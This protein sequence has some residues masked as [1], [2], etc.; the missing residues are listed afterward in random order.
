MSRKPQE[1]NPLHRIS[2]I[3]M[4]MSHTPV[5]DPRRSFREFIGRL[6]GPIGDQEGRL[7]VRERPLRVDIRSLVN[8]HRVRISCGKLAA[9]RVETSFPPG[10]IADA[11]P[12][13]VPSVGTR[14][15]IPADV[16]SVIEAIGL[17][18]S[19][20]DGLSS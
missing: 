7:E 13:T 4:G 1:G 12:P 16:S 10:C 17:L 15:W 5:D 9:G 20:T 3:L 6:R 14:S 11:S 8:G 18:G 2:D 19:D